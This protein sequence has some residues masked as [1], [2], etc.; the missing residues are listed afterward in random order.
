[1][2]PECIVRCHPH[3]DKGM[4]A[5]TKKQRNFPRDIL[6]TKKL[7]VE[8]FINKKDFSTSTRLHR[9]KSL[10][11]ELVAEIWKIEAMCVG[12]RPNQWPR[13]WFLV[14][15]DMIELLIIKSHIDN[16][17]NNQEDRLA[18]SL[19]RDIIDC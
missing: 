12:L 16:Y 15:G 13:I 10:D 2:R 8:K 9:V 1:M 4:K 11:Y 7:L 18:E 6:H 5:F 3:F 14:Y 17:D 19:V